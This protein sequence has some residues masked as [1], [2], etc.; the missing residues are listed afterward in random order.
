MDI[1]RVTRDLAGNGTLEDDINSV[2]FG[3]GIVRRPAC[4]NVQ[5]APD[6][7]FGGTR[8]FVASMEGGDYRLVIQTG[9][10]G[11]AGGGGA[12]RTNVVSRRLASPQLQ[13][14]LDA[15]ATVFE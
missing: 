5:S 10:G 6:E 1:V 9:R 15:W 8:A 2:L 7:F 12:Q 4:P 3:V 14:R 11:T 13:V